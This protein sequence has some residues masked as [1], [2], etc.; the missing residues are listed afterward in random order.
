MLWNKKILVLRFIKKHISHKKTPQIDQ[1]FLLGLVLK[2]CI[3]NVAF[4][5]NLTK[6]N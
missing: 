2:M 5:T 6:R 3:E 4:I 1:K